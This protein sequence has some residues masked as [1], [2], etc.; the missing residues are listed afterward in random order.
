MAHPAKDLDQQRKGPPVPRVDEIAKEKQKAEQ[1]EIAGRHK[2]DG[3]NDGKSL[4]RNHG[5]K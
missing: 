4:Q 2:N 5:R 1:E 3:K